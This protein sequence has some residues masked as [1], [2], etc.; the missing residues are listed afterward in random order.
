MRVPARLTWVC[1]AAQAAGSAESRARVP[2]GEDGNRLVEVAAAGGWTNT[3]VASFVVRARHPG[4]ADRQD[5]I[6][7]HAGSAAS[8][9]SAQTETMSMRE[10]G[11]VADG[12]PGCGQHGDVGDRIENG[13]APLVPVIAKSPSPNDVPL[14]PAAPGDPGRVTV[15]VVGSQG[16]SQLVREPS[17]CRHAA[18]APPSTGRIAPWM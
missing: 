11:D 5:G 9:A 15:P 13:S 17:R 14:S 18:I 7:K 2:E 12:R 1:L 4:G 8:G 16:C 10:S 3:V 6:G